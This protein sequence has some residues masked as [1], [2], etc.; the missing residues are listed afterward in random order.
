MQCEGSPILTQ[1]AA[2]AQT[3]GRRKWHLV[4]V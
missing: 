1:V 3:P 4:S 2:L